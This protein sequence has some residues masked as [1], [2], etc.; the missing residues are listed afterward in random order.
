MRRLKYSTAAVADFTELVDPRFLDWY[1]RQKTEN[2]Q[3][4]G[5]IA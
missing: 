3:D 5:E 4:R 1:R 2:E